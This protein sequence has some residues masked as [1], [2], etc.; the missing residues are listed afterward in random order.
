MFPF[1]LSL[2]LSSRSCVPVWM[3]CSVL[4][5]QLQFGHLPHRLITK[6]DA[7][8]ASFCHAQNE[9]NRLNPHLTT[10]YRK[11]SSTRCYSPLIIFLIMMVWCELP[12]CTFLGLNIIKPVLQQCV[13]HEIMT[14]LFK[15]FHSACSLM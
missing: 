7:R 1:S 14:Q 12:S 9:L 5:L 6:Y 2:L 11:E 13:F 15:I 4:C 3:S 8:Q 10:V